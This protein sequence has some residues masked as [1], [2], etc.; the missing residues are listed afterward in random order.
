MHFNNIIIIA[1][2]HVARAECL[3]DGPDIDEA[4]QALLHQQYIVIISSWLH[5]LFHM[6]HHSRNYSVTMYTTLVEY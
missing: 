3:G 4:R 2:L 6:L 5:L 1:I